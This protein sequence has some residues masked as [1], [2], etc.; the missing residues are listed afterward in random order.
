M[1]PENASYK[2]QTRQ[3]LWGHIYPVRVMPVSPGTWDLQPQTHKYRPYLRYWSMVT[4]ADSRNLMGISTWT[5]WFVFTEP[6]LERLDRTHHDGLVM[7]VSEHMGPHHLFI[8]G[9]TFDLFVGPGGT[10]ARGQI[11]ESRDAVN[12]PPEPAPVSRF[13]STFAVELQTR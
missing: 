7:L 2:T 9:F 11:L 1:K 4:V 12:P 10:I 5:L 8:P 13:S 3:F 6:P